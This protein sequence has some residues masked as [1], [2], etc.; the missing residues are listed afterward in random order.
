M[1][2][3]ST[4]CN[5]LLTTSGAEDF[6]ATET[7]ITEG[8]N[9]NGAAELSVTK[10]QPLPA[11]STSL[12]QLAGI[13]HHKH[14]ETESPSPPA[15]KLSTFSKPTVSKSCPPLK[16]DF[17]PIRPFSDLSFLGCN[18]DESASLIFPSAGY[19]ADE[20]SLNDRRSS[21]PTGL[22]NELDTSTLD[23][24]S[25][26]NRLMQDTQQLLKWS[27]VASRSSPLMV[28]WACKKYINQYV[29]INPTYDL[30][31]LCWLWMKPEMTWPN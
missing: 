22:G 1:F 7:E 23:R 30:T 13:V 27:V 18:Q 31:G 14:R 6:T 25:R 4:D 17:S 21:T 19:A 8:Q 5:S 26:I 28:D 29:L 3:F 20:S 16:Q 24:V 9:E 12:S 2:F 15:Q 10:P 11:S